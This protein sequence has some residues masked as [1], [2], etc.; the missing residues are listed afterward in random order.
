MMATTLGDKINTA[1][2]KEGLDAAIEI[3]DSAEAD[4][5]AQ[6]YELQEKIKDLES[7]KD[8]FPLEDYSGSPDQDNPRN[9]DR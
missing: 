7:F 3:A 2:S 9:F 4:F 1:L 8:T 5:E 6:I